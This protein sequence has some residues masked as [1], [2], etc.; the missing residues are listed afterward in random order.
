MLHMCNYHLRFGQGGMKA[1]VW[2][3]TLQMVIL[4]MGLIA[5]DIAGLFSIG[6]FSIVWDTAKQGGRNRFFK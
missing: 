5:I 1:V 4:F 2:T 3:D 6:S